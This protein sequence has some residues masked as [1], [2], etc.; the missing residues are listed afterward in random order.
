MYNSWPWFRETI[1]LISM[2]LSKSDMSIN[3][4]YDAQLVDKTDELLSLGKEIRNRL[5]QTRSGVL[6]VTGCEDVTAG[7][8]LLQESMKTR[9]AFVDPIN[10]IQA[11]VMKRY[12]ALEKKGDKLTKA[13]KVEK[14]ILVDGLRV[15]ISGIAQGMR[16]SG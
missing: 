8:H 1:D 12:R 4:N 7:F 9:A 3:A 14:E 10:C 11:E 13:E 5:A 16:N 6:K 2:V 15:C